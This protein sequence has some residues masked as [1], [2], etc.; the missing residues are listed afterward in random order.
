[1]QFGIGLLFAVFLPYLI[2]TLVPLNY[3]G[4]TGAATLQNSFLGTILAFVGGAYGYLQLAKYPGVRHVGFV[5]PS[6]AGSFG[7]VLTFFFM[8]RIDYSRAQF[9]GSFFLSIL[10]FLLVSSKT[11]GRR[12]YRYGVVPFGRVTELFPIVEAEWVRLTPD[13]RDGE[14]VDAIAADLHADLPDDWERFLARKA[15]GGTMV[16]HYRQLREALTGRVSI[17]HLSENDLGSIIPGV[18][19]AKA[20]RTMD[21]IAALVALPVLAPVLLLIAVAVKLD[22]PGPAL[23]HQQR[24]GYR[25]QPFRMHK[26]RTMQSRPVEEEDRDQA[27]TRDADPRITRLGRFMRQMRIDELPQ[28]VNVLRGEMSWIGPRPEALA[29]SEWYEQEL[30]FYQ[31][32]HIVRPGLTGWAQ[33]RQ[34]HV[35]EV[36]EVLAKLHYDFYY[37]RN[38]TLWLD[39]LII[40]KTIRTILTGFG[41]R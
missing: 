30:P 3:L 5:V 40:A 25:G 16:A 6:F 15:L 27:I 9:A 39:L 35:A 13:N 14:V 22:S 37:I 31:Y 12:I 1:M 17:E 10:W 20:K 7:L 24:M 33:V 29:L 36:D 38:F 28:I 8:A 41:A 23:F 32:R 34:G 11:S 21:F 18:L 2:R 19:Y 26:F 4:P